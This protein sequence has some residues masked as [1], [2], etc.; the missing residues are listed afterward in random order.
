VRAVTLVAAAVAAA[1]SLYVTAPAPGT[2]VSTAAGLAA[3]LRLG[4]PIVLADGTY[5]RATP[6]RVPARTT[7]RAEHPGKAV[8]RM[9]LS[10]AGPGVTVDGLRFSIA[11]PRRGANGAAIEVWGGPRTTIED[12]TVDGRRRLPQ[13]I[14]VRTPAGFVG[15]RLVA[16]NLTSDGIVVDSYPRR[17]V[18][19]PVPVLEDVDVAGVARPVP[20][21]SKGT[22]EACLWLGVRI[23]LQGA[24]LRDC[25]WMG[26][27]TGFD[28]V[29]S[30]YADV[31]VDRTPVGVYVEHYTTRSLFANLHVGP[32]VR[33]GVDCEWADPAYG[34]RPASTGNVIRDSAFE[35]YRVGVYL[36][37]GT[38]T[39][40]VVRSTFRGQQAAAI[41]DFRGRG[42]RY[43]GNRYAPGVTPVTHAHP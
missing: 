14:V 13:A 8:L 29:G 22:A 17:V 1:C 11:E 34:R 5:A 21:S 25:A 24:R 42:N 30:R 18:P 15:R 36:D 33:T 39:T 37:E 7:L 35:S 16:R 20:R 6:L 12:V 10:V 26:L 32:H 2:R 3:A 40:S 9:G 27:W 28:S 23:R 41:V 4:G 19:S 31:D 43:V 38:R